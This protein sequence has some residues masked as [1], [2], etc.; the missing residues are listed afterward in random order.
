MNSQKRVFEILQLLS[1]A[2]LLILPMAGCQ[3]SDQAA[4]VPAN[5]PSDAI[6]LTPEQVR[7]IRT[8]PVELTSFHRTIEATGTVAF[9]QN[10]STEVL[11]PISG[12]V[13]KILVDVGARVRRGDALAVIASPDFADALSNLRKAAATA[14]NTRRIADRDKELFAN[15][16]ISRVDVENAETD[17]SNATADEDAARQQL[18]SLGVDEKTLDRI[19]AGQPVTISGGVIRSPIEG[20]VVERLITPGQL[21]SAGGSPCFTVA[22][23]SK[24]WVIANVFE[25]DLPG[26]AAGDPAEVLVGGTKIPA[27]V[28][29][30]AAMVDPSTRAVSV[31]LTAANPG[32][33]LKRDMYVRTLIES[34]TA[35]KGIVVPVSAVLRDEENLPFVFVGRSGGTFVRQRVE[36]GQRM[37]DHI[38]ITSG[39]SAGENIVVEGALFLG[40]VEHS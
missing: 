3:G 24:V 19:A 35:A 8:A 37:D 20:T 17:A 38:E 10:R 28:Q 36:T 14:V 40:T 29:Y 5:D 2:A 33:I 21:L 26:V 39:L 22:D 30:I 25:K 9:D 32:G 4:P 11:A 13:S 1:V 7:G 23:L 18:R 31:R 27:T 15:D 34:K 12:P 16:A 6:R